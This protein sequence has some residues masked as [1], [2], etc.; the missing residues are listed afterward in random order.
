MA[1]AE[2]D[3]L[4]AKTEELITN[5]EWQQNPSVGYLN[6]FDVLVHVGATESTP[7]L[8]DLIQRKDRRDLA[9]AG[10]L[11]LDRLVLPGVAWPRHRDHHQHRGE[12]GHNR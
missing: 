1:T 3:Y 2:R 4:R 9:H 12:T 5:P 10:F 8:S 7:L 6:A 11:A